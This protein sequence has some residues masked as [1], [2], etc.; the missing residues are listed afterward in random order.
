MHAHS[1]QTLRICASGCGVAVCVWVNVGASDAAATATLPLLCDSIEMLAICIR[2]LSSKE[3]FNRIHECQSLNEISTSQF[4]A[5]DSEST[6]VIHELID[7][8]VESNTQT[9]S[10]IFPSSSM[11]RSYALTSMT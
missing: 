8:S 11:Q 3:R 7:Q 10:A 4:I 2:C 1:S 6:H 9:I 5:V